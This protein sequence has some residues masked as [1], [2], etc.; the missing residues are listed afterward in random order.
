MISTTRSAGAAALLVL[1]C[2]LAST[3]LHAESNNAPT[4][5]S[6]DELSF[7]RRRLAAA[8]DV[9]EETLQKQVQTYLGG[10]S[11]RVDLMMAPLYLRDS[12]DMNVARIMDITNL[13]GQSLARDLDITF[14]WIIPGAP[15][16]MMKNIMNFCYGK[17]RPEQLN[18]EPSMEFVRDNIVNMDTSTPEGLE[19][20]HNNSLVDSNAIDFVVST[21][22][23]SGS[24]LF[25]EAHMGR[26]FAIFQHP[27]ERALS[28]FHSQR[29]INKAL[30]QVSFEQHV[31]SDYFFDNW[32]VRQLTGTMPWVELDED[33]LARAKNTIQRKIFVGVQDQ[34]GETLRQL[35]M[36]YDWS[37]IEEGCTSNFV[38]DEPAQGHPGLAGGRG[39]KTWNVLVEKEKWDMSLYHFALQL[40]SQQNLRYSGGVEVE[41]GVEE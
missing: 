2:L 15:A 7:V 29:K 6:S 39:G 40:F 35:R 28:V 41:E 30:Q 3:F 23:L 16:N 8:P 22:F 20:S 4:I 17:R 5:T 36:H 27:V 25:N 37:D 18:A 19:F 26:A 13:S 21:Y 24:A 10:L 14:F 38:K 32:M 12:A 31:K 11:P 33:R 9:D 34:M 1:G